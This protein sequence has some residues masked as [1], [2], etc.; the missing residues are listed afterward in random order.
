[1]LKA[2]GSLFT[3]LLL[4]AIAGAVGAYFWFQDTVSRPG[5]LA[6]DTVFAVSPG[7][8]LIGVAARAE[9]Q[10]II[11]DDRLLRL[12]ARVR[13]Q[14]T[15]IKTG[16][17]AVEAGISTTGFLDLLV[18]GVV[19]QYTI[20]FPE[21]LTTAQ[22]ASRI[23]ADDRLQGALPDPLPG[24]GTL[25][26]ETYA[27]ARGTTKAELLQRM[28]TAQ[29]SLLDQLWE[30]RTASLPLNDRAEALTLASIVQKE[31]ADA[32]EY[33]KVASVFINR[34]ER[35]MKLET[36]VT[37]HYGVNGGEPLMN[38]DGQ[39]R[40]LYRSELDRDTP[41]NTYTREGLPPT[42]IANPGEGAIR[43][44]LNPPETDY[45]FFVASGTGG[46]IFTTNY[47]D[48]QRAVA[49]YRAYERAEIARERA[50]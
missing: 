44:T 45:L 34:L 2:L 26:P 6:E 20:T 8:T 48:H 36:D 35:G 24:E 12:Q 3:I 13:D 11:S 1:M 18:S 21:G 46:S 10:G 33:G 23:D 4:L 31:S 5:P 43:A 40:T 41:Y 22:I 37:V 7:E 19:I 47:S 42:P 16:E 25:L 17:F 30:S 49:D 27:F 32:G 39:R 15:A 50:N 28:S 38:R 9:A 14:E 29:N